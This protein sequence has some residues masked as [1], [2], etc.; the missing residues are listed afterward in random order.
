MTVAEFLLKLVS[1]DPDFVDA[2]RKDMDKVMR[3]HGVDDEGRRLILAGSIEELRFEI[4]TTL[5]GN[6]EASIIW[7]HHIPWL[8]FDQSS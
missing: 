3:E 6:D 8:F 4:K 1:A 2:F 7:I 5:A